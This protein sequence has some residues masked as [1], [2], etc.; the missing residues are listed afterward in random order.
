MHSLGDCTCSR[1]EP[2]YGDAMKV[3]V[4]VMPQSCG[5]RS[6]GSS[7]ARRNAASWNAGSAQRPDR[8]YLEID[9][10][11]KDVEM[12]RACRVFAAICFRIR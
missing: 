10:D 7:G 1:S 6:A 12:K 8:K 2:Q 5:A 3:K 4:V 9:V 11:G